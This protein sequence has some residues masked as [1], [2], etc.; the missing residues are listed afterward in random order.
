M[1]T[2]FDLALLSKQENLLFVFLNFREKVLQLFLQ[3]VVLSLL[4][5]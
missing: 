3:L 1:L 4:F 2:K 5:T